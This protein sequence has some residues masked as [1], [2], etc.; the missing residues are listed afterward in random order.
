MAAGVG[1]V[2]GPVK[3]GR[4]GCTRC[5]TVLTVGPHFH[6]EGRPVLING[7]RWSEV[8][9]EDVEQWCSSRGFGPIAPA[10]ETERGR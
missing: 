5:L 10:P 2:A 8:A 4:Q 3:D 6:P 7:N 9:R 1:H